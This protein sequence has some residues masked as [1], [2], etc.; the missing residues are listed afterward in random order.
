MT[1]VVL[2]LA[3][4]TP[5]EEEDRLVGRQSLPLSEDAVAAVGK[6]AESLASQVKSVYR[7]KTNEAC[8]EAAK[9]LAGA[10]GVRAR[11]VDDLEEIN[12]GLWQGLR[13]DELRFRFKSAFEQWEE[14]PLSVNPPDGETLENAITRL[15]S[16][17]KRILRRNRGSVSAVA[18]RPMAMQALAGILRFEEPAAIASHLHQSAPMETIELSRQDLHRFLL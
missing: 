6:I 10:V 18:T 11:D 15:R 17:M 2:I 1:R 12:L 3:G 7:C 4:P 13:F 14:N 9:I 8:D 16:A 5:W